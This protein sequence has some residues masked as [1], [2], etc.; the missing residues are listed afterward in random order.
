MGFVL[1]PFVALA[2]VLARKLR[3]NWIEFNLGEGTYAQSSVD[4]LGW[5][6]GRANDTTV[7]FGVPVLIQG[8]IGEDILGID[9]E[10]RVTRS[11][12]RSFYHYAAAVS[13]RDRAHP[14]AYLSQ[15]Y[16]EKADAV[17]A[18]RDTAELI[19]V[20]AI[21]SNTSTVS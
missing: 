11:R 3:Y 15:F 20:P 14:A 16:K 7:R 17:S 9:I 19:G 5:R 8:R 4:T 12:R 6:G 10:M 18:A 2:F 13:W 1:L 21:G